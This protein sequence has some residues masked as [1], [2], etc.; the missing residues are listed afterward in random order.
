MK[1]ILLTWKTEKQG[2]TPWTKMTTSHTFWQR[3]KGL[4]VV[5]TPPP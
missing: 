1:Q 5:P 3:L 4:G 2:I